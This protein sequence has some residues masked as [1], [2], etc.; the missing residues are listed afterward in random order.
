MLQQVLLGGGAF[1]FSSAPGA[2]VSQVRH[3]EKNTSKDVPKVP[4]FHQENI[5]INNT[6][7]ARIIHYQLQLAFLDI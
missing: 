5:I 2:E 1:F 7:A 6:T 3:A 4:P